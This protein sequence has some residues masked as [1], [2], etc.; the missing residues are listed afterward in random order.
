MIEVP[1]GI[2][3]LHLVG[4]LPDSEH[5]LPATVLWWGFDAKFRRIVLT[6]PR[7]GSPIFEGNESSRSIH[8]FRQRLTS[9][10]C[11]SIPARLRSKCLRV[12]YPDSHICNCG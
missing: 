3:D 4:S 6:K 9:T 2:K 1:A 5:L 8:R 10:I 11:A 7:S 12:T